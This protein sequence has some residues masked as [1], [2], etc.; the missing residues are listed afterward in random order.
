MKRIHGLATIVKV[1]R[2]RARGMDY[3]DS[4]S[5]NQVFPA[6]RNEMFGQL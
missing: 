1:P 6:S 4:G 2:H 5:V 3:V